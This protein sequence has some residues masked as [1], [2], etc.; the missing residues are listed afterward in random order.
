MKILNE[1]ELNSFLEAVSKAKGNI[2]LKSV[3]G[4]CFNLKSP[5]SCYVAIGE[6]LSEHGDEL[7]L[8]CDNRSDEKFFFKFFKENPEVLDGVV[9]QR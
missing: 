8:F 3:E 7:E 2:F 6:L 1:K 9:V 4:D 5:L